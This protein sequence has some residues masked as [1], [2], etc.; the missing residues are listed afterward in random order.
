M[1]SHD[2]RDACTAQCDGCSSSAPGRE[3]KPADALSGGGLVAASGL[4]FLGPVLLGILAGLLT[5]GQGEGLRG[6]AVMAGLAGGM[7][8]SVLAVR[9]LCPGQRSE[10]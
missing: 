8:L 7:L 6:L 5:A 2:S 10:S 3:Q 9:W 1:H 4:F